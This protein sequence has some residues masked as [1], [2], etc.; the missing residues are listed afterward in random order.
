MIQLGY[1]PH[2]NPMVPMPWM[3]NYQA[4]LAHQMQQMKLMMSQPP[5][6]MSQPPGMMSQPPGMMSQPPM[7]MSQPPG[8]MEMGYPPGF[9]PY[10]YPAQPAYWQL[11]PPH[12]AAPLDS[13]PAMIPPSA[14]VPIPGMEG[15]EGGLSAAGG[16]P[17]YVPVLPMGSLYMPQ[18]ALDQQRVSNS[19]SL[20]V[21]AKR[22]QAIPIVSPPPPQQ[23]DTPAEVMFCESF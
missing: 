16:G 1:G 17:S 8:V 19:P 4:Y 5:G 12:S 2:G 6:M 18:V 14:P 10:M 21:T 7:M 23:Q 22:S 11:P 15:G 20:P 9:M 13:Y 3:G